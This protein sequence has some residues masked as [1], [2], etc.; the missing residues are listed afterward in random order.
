MSKTLLTNPVVPF[1]LLRAL[2]CQFSDLCATFRFPLPAICLW[3]GIAF[4]WAQG[5]HPLHHT[6]PCQF[7][8]ASGN[9][10]QPV[11]NRPP[12]GTR[13]SI[14]L[15]QQGL[16]LSSSL[17]SALV[18]WAMAVVEAVVVMTKISYCGVRRLPA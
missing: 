18:L 16:S 4:R 2:R 8:K 13:S 15:Q 1:H 14:D 11:P 9:L 10:G 6:A 3:Q 17:F 5:Q 12:P 7:F